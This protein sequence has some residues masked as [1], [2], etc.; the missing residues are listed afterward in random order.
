MDILEFSIHGRPC[1]LNNVH[2]FFSANF[3]R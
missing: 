2:H 1:L 3:N